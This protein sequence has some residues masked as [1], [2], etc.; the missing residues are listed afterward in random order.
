[1]VATHLSGLFDGTRGTRWHAVERLF[2]ICFQALAAFALPA[3]AVGAKA[4][5]AHAK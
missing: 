2:L 3:D 4:G 1:L 5:T